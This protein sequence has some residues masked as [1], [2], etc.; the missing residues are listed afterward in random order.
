MKEK[1]VGFMTGEQIF[2]LIIMIWFVGG[3]GLIFAGIGFRASRAKKPVGF[4]TGKE[5]KVESVTDIPAY[6]AENARMWYWY[7]APYF[8]SVLLSILGIQAE[9]ANKA[10]I[11]LITLA[12]TVGL[13]WLIRTYRKI[14][15]RYIRS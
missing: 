6:N 7:S 11:G 10:A 2:G 5:V 8:L 15:K 1:G 14:E 12:C 3:C 9:W 13:W 4:W